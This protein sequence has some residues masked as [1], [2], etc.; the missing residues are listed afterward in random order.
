MEKKMKKLALICLVISLLFY[1]CSRDKATKSKTPG[2]T[3][4]P[5][6]AAIELQKIRI[7]VNELLD[8]ANACS[9]ANK[10]AEALTYVRKLVDISKQFPGKP[11]FREE[12]LDFQ[13][14]LLMKTG[15]FQEALENGLALEALAQK[16]STRESPW[17]CLK[18]AE[19]YLGLKDQE[20]ALAWIERAVYER[21][22][23]RRD[24][25]TAQDYSPLKNNPRFVK[26]IAAIEKKIGLNLPAKE[27]GVRLLDGKSFTLSGQR[28]KVVL[29]DFWDV[30]CPPCRKE[31]PNLRKLQ[32][33]FAEKGLVI[34]GISL[35]TD[36]TLL[37]NYLKEI[38]PEWKMACSF[39]GW[40]DA[41]AKLYSINATPSS[42]LIDRN[43]I[44]RHINLRGEELYTAVRALL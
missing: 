24:I 27:F 3:N 17:N 28:G 43:G 7:Q 44:L 2:K 16:I 23:I 25:L 41:T 33:E 42:W 31:M 5:Q 1:G 4:A 19:A 30:K 34:V 11:E 39:Q 13:Q 40:N 35:D 36:K 15:A 18:I 12:M 37:Q 20:N 9:D 38:S 32:R 6:A 8:R 14:Y 29:I 10:Y 21:G 22:F 26:V